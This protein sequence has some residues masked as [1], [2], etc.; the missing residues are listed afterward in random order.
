[1]DHGTQQ[2][3]V[4]RGLS[5]IAMPLVVLAALALPLAW[6]AVILSNSV[7]SPRGPSA[8]RGTGKSLRHPCCDRKMMVRHNACLANQSTNGDSE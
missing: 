2:R 6:A 5:E 3:T 1:M 4:R 7:S 8:E